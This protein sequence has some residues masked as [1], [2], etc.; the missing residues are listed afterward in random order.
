M[1]G[2]ALRRNHHFVPRLYLKRFANSRGKIHVYRTLVSHNHVPLWKEA[3][4]RGVAYHAHLY[5]RIVAG[6]ESD[7]FERWLDT[8]FEAPAEEALERAVA[9]ERLTPEH[10]RRLIR[11]L[12][13]QDVRTPARLLE[14]IHRWNR[15]LPQLIED[16][17]QES[18]RKLEAARE[19]GNVLPQEDALDQDAIPVRV[20]TTLEPGEEYGELGAEVLA[21]RGLWLSQAKRL[22]TKTAAVLHQH[23]WTILKASDG[24]SWFTSDDPVLKLNAYSNG[25]YDFKGG[26]GNPG[27]EIFLPLSPHH[28]LYTKVGERPPR[29][30]E[31][32]QPQMAIL[33]RRFI[34][35]HAHRMI[36]APAPQPEITDF[37]S[38][39]VDGEAYRQEQEQWKRW[40]HEQTA[41]ERRFMKGS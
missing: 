21:G 12:A 7:E 8:E 30:G 3:S 35:E 23:R 36:F 10:W 5:T 15:E 28:L 1:D 29:R 16:S 9:G 32:M 18:V 33:I 27:T 26:W 2:S 20:T 31:V 25:T 17:L 6:H 38:R 19:S 34:A 11:F 40:H 24:V 41:A 22:L 14:S 4:V 13:A 39:T 37:R